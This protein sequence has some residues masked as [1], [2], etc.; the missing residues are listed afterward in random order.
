MTTIVDNYYFI[1]TYQNYSELSP[2]VLQSATHI[3]AGEHGYAST[4]IPSGNHDNF[5]PMD[6]LT[7]NHHFSM[8]KWGLKVSIV[9]QSNPISAPKRMISGYDRV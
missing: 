5:S 6:R 3:N 9:S 1:K 7:G 4:R 2:T 8:N